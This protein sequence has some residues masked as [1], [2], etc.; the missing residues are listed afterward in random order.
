MWAALRE[1]P[2]GQTRTYGEV[3]AEIGR[4]TAVRAVANA[5]GRN[6]LAVATPC[7]RVVGA[8]GTL[9]GYRWGAARKQ[10]LLAM[11]ADGDSIAPLNATS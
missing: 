2:R 5:C 1:I 4:P 7:H 3:A 8:G 11:E 9:G 6:P 10:A